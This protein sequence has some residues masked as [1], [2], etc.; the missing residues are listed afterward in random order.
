MMIYGLNFKMDEIFLDLEV[1]DNKPLS[2]IIEI[3]L[4]SSD[5]SI[6]FNELINPGSE[7]VLSEY[8]KNV[9][10]YDQDKL[11]QARSLEYYMPCLKQLT[12]NMNVVA[13]GKSDLDKL[14]WLKENSVYSDCCQRFAERNGIFSKYHGNHQWM[15]LK[16]A[17]LQIGYSPIGKPHRSLTDA[18]SCRQVWVDLDKQNANI[19]TPFVGNSSGNLISLPRIRPSIHIDKV[20][21]AKEMI[22]ENTI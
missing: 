2:P 7:F 3:S 18:E 6:L 22:N 10:G 20:G 4:L 15:S 9:L 8:K 16:D 13:Y 12:K 1:M 19:K 17:C 21:E 11:N 5:G 14:P